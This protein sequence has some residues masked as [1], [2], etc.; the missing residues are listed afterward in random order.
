MMY[1]FG[2]GFFWLLV[3]ALVVVGVVWAVR[4][5]GAWQRPPELPP[6]ADPRRILDERLARG[7]IDEEEY[8]RRRDT[9]SR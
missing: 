3:V 4:N 1:G 8:R 2:M 5:S 7:E 6:P 9:L